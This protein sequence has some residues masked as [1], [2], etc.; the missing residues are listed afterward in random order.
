MC[1]PKRT[2]H[3]V[4]SSDYVGFSIEHYKYKNFSEVASVA[5]Q[6]FPKGV[7]W[8]K[9][10]CTMSQKQFIV[11]LS[12]EERAALQEIARTGKQKARLLRRA[13]MLLWSDAGKSD[14]E[15]AALLDVT[16]LTVAITR[17]RWVTQHNLGDAPRSGRPPKT[18]GKQDAMLIALACSQAP[19]GQQRWTMTLLAE[20][21]VELGVV[22]HAIS[23]ETVRRRL[24]KTTSSRG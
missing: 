3:N 14:A 5:P 9:K 18:D 13:Q 24:K 17:R 7:Y 10:A 6:K 19:E 8:L 2:R 4:F 12:E 1:N 23:D 21:L 15:I 22:E 20:R 11:H 16:P